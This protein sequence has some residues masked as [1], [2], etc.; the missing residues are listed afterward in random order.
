[1]NSMRV[2]ETKSKTLNYIDNYQIIFFSFAFDF[3]TKHTKNK[4][5]KALLQALYV[6]DKNKKQFELEYHQ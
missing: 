6:Q 5:I 2:L 4:M 3:K 1:M